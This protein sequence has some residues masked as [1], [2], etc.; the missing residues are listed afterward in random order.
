[1]PTQSD[2]LRVVLR[3]GE[4]IVPSLD[5]A[6]SGSLAEACHTIGPQLT[7]ALEGRRR[8]IYI[9]CVTRIHIYSTAFT[10][11]KAFDQWHHMSTPTHS[12]GYLSTSSWG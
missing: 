4:P 1:M 2:I 6:L 5:R 9:V 8:D 7:T 10:Q 12:I 3:V 11:S